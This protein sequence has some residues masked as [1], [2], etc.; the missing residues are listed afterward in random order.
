MSSKWSLSFRFPHQNS[1]HTSLRPLHVTWPAQLIVL[2]LFRVHTLSSSLL[3]NFLQFPVSSSLLGPNI[4]LITLSLCSSFNVRDQVSHPC[5]T[6]GRIILPCIII[7]MLLNNKLK[8][9]MFWAN[10][11][12]HSLNLKCWQ[13]DSCGTSYYRKSCNKSKVRSEKFGSLASLIYSH[14]SLKFDD[15]QHAC[16][17]VCVTQ[18]VFTYSSITL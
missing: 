11:C 17:K 4:F 12:K 16:A 18:T 2:D 13:L 8:D 10:G 5:K 14:S 6:T 15:S 7:F 3:C 9:K 1:V